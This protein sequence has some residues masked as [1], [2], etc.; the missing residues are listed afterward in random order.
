MKRRYLDQPRWRPRFYITVA[1]LLAIVFY[2]SWPLGL[3]T[4]P[5]AI[6][7]ATQRWHHEPEQKKKS[8]GQR[9]R[10]NH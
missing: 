9:H 6:Y 4:L 10:R 5:F 2:A 3:L 1:I 8:T 7:Y